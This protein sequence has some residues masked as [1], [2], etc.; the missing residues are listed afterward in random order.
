V[1]SPCQTQERSAPER[2]SVNCLPPGQHY[3][4]RAEQAAN[5]GL[6]RNKPAANIGS[7]YVFLLPYLLRG[8]GAEGK[9]RMLI[10]NPTAPWSL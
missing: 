8:D 10:F 1:A 5:L 6:R 9:G 4:R 3:T 2:R 7:D